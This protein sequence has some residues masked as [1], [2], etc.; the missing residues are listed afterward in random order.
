M[1][2]HAPPPLP[3]KLVAVT[4]YPGMEEYPS[5]SPDGKQI[6]FYWD[7]EKGVNPGIYVKLVG[8]TNALR[9]TSGQD[10]YPAWSP[11]GK[12]IAFVRGVEP[13]V[14]K[15]GHAIYTVSA[16][17]GGERKISDME[18]SRQISWSPDGKWLAM[19]SGNLYGSAIFVLPLLG[20][21]PRRISDPKSPAFDTAPAFSPDGHRLAYVGCS[22]RYS[23]D[24]YVL[25][26]GNHGAPGGHPRQVTRQG[27]EMY[28][29]T[30]SR[31]G[32]SLV[33]SAAHTLMT[34]YLWRTGSDGR[35]TPQRVEIAGPMAF[36]PSASPT[37]ERL[38]YEKSLLDADIWRY[39]AGCGLD[40]ILMSSLSDFAPQ[41]SPDGTSIVF[42]S[43][44]SGER[45]EIW[46]AQ[47]DGSRPVQ[48]TNGPGRNQGTPRWSP[49][50]RWIAFDSE[51]EDGHFA[52]YVMDASGSSPRKVTSESMNTHMPFWAPGG[53]WIYF[54]A[55][56]QI[57]RV[58]FAGGRAETVTTQGASMGYFSADGTALFYTKEN[59][60]P[61]F[62]K[63]LAGGE[64]HQVLPYVNYKA[65][66]PTADGIYYIGRREGDGYFPLEFYQFSSK[67]SRVLEKIGGQIYQG[68]TVS[69]GGKSILF[70]RSPS[71]SDLMMIE[72]F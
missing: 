52:I 64:E 42:C 54:T 2:L 45:M 57:W 22:F 28:G 61:V 62:A 59:A 16:L 25:E 21:E 53:E 71:G 43:N 60:G 1:K 30:W 67:T 70:S 66:F 38:L 69:P 20:G 18:V 48:L 24:V 6:A 14:F 32:R 11:D 23:C 56:S 51:G 36:A 46:V 68:L 72:N 63:S 4:T 13:G 49:D 33:Y 10:A 27:M 34:P 47:A 50:G 35:G 31:D 41:Y 37:A 5:F 8:E 3:Q 40:P 65:F 44:R 39:R 58:P 26:L 19:A 17:G 55:N 15:T 29:L 7:G 9:L 12:R